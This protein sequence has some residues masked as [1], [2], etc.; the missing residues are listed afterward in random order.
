M[1]QK[2]PFSS[3][4]MF[5]VSCFFLEV[6]NKKLL[7]IREEDLTMDVASVITITQPVD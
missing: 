5:W 6:E 2:E 1:R 7:N 3:V 4:F